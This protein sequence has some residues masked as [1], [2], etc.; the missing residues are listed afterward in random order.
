MPNQPVYHLG[1]S[2]PIG[3]LISCML[4]LFAI[5]STGWEMKM[6]MEPGGPSSLDIRPRSKATKVIK[7]IILYRYI[8][9]LFL[10]PWPLPERQAMVLLPP[11][12]RITHSLT[13]SLNRQEQTCLQSLQLE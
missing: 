8:D 5:A 12:G 4:S 11:C 1:L 13:I 7:V 2:Y 6:K 9:G 3:I 10:L